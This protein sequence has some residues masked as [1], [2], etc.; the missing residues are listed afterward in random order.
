MKMVVKNVENSQS[1][2]K[3]VDYKKSI[4]SLKIFL[5]FS[6]IFTII[7]ALFLICYMK[8][9]IETTVQKVLMEH[10]ANPLKR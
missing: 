2:D 9:E 10:R 1:V 6:Y 3:N 8:S 5:I 4:S 7:V